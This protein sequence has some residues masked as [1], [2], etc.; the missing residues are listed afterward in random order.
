MSEALNNFY[1]ELVAVTAEIS[2]VMGGSYPTLAGENE[3]SFNG[4]DRLADAAR[5]WARAVCYV[6]NWDGEWIEA[7]GLYAHRIKEIAALQNEHSDP[8]THTDFEELA[9]VCIAQAYFGNN[10]RVMPG[11]AWEKY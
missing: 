10:R 1:R 8:F 4:L 6:K 11:S 3:D 9:K 7:I 2:E 5:G